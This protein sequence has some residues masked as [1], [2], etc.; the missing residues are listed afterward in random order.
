MRTML[1]ALLLGCL[2]GLVAGECPNA[3]GSHGKCGAFD[4]VFANTASAN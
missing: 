3:C 2:L 4:M 1:L